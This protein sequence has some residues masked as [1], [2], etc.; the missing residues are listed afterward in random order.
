M[1][2]AFERYGWLNVGCFHLGNVD[3]LEPRCTRDG[4]KDMFGKRKWR[5]AIMCG[6]PSNPKRARG[7]PVADEPGN[8]SRENW[9]KTP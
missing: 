6:K 1:T 4:L 7:K 3:C 8:I 9:A 2:T 5:A